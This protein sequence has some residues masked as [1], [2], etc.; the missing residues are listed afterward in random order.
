MAKLLGRKA[1]LLIATPVG[2]SLTSFRADV[3]EI[4][5][6]RLR[7][8][9]KKGLRK[10]PNTAKITVTNLSERSRAELQD[11]AL[12]VT[13]QAG[14]EDT[15][16]TIFVGDIRDVNSVHEGA[17]W[18]TALECGDGERGYRFARINESFKSGSSV[19]A[20]TR[21]MAEKMGVDASTAAAFLSELS[22]KQFVAGYAARGNVSK[23]LDRLLKAHGFD[24]S[25]QD[26]KLQILKTGDVT[27]E[28]AVE[29]DEDSGLI[30]S[31]TF[32]TPEKKTK[33]PTLKVRSLLQ[34]TIKP[35]GRIVVRSQTFTGTFKVKEVTHSGDTAGGEF[36]SDMEGEPL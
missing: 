16:A 24:W 21:K 12:R 36:Y 19:L 33:K 25:I 29:L 34:P 35:G 28:T 8:S 27:Q 13:L 32:G 26:N 22:G 9:V 4:E 11:K 30:G 7:F 18:E 5:D 10:E 2:L 6:L 17:Y 20:V 1:K 3:F 23:E 14:Y 15:L 31:P